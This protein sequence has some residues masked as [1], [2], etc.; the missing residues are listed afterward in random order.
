V[1]NAV[2]TITKTPNQANYN[3][4]DT[5]TYN[6]DITNNGPDTATN[7]QV[8]DTL[9]AGL[10][11]ISG[12]SYNPATRLITWTLATLLAG[13]HFQPSFTATVNPGTQGN[14]IDN[15]ASA[16]DDQRPTP[17]TSNTASIHINNAPLTVT[18]T[19]DRSPAE[20]NVG[21][22]VIYTIDVVNNVEGD[23][24]TGVVVTDTLPAGLTYVSS[25]NSGVWDP[26][27]RT[28]TWTVGDLASGAH[29]TPTVTATVTADAAAKH[30]ENTA[31]AIDDEMEDPVSAI[32]SIYVPSADL[33]LSKTVDNTTPV[34]KDTVTFTLIVNNHG[35]DTAV[36]VTVND[37]LP[38]GLT[39]VSSS[40]NYGTYNPNTGIWTIGNLPNGETAILT[41]K[42]VVEKSGQIINQAKVTAL[43]YDPNIEGNTASATMNAQAQT[44]PVNAKTVTNAK[45]VSMQETGAPFGALIVAVLMMLAG[46]VL[47]RRK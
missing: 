8:T 28:V 21:E 11:W 4:G 46:I 47:P 2:L 41:I 43:T 29:F 6:L 13:S 24:A 22:N 37:K 26:I 39:Y 3:V 18:K 36:D 31:Q 15:T 34:V 23:P 42:A 7:L 25:S 33:V 45:T 44:V 35:P 38:A 12:G 32:A 5:V 19:T 14:T 17:V 20:Y 27:T 1:N 40:A 10:T 16:R 9:P 30:L